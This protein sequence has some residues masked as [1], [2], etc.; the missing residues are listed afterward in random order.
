MRNT[1]KYTKMY[2]GGEPQFVGGDVFR[3][4]IP[5]TEAATATVEP[6][7]I[8]PND[9]EI[10]DAI[11]DAINLSINERKLIQFLKENPRATKTVMS[12]SL[13]IGVAAIDRTIK[14]LKQQLGFLERVGSN[15]T[16]YWKV[17]S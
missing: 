4:T 10:N 13:E 5:L 17:N 2:S 14:K 16:G 15:K 12:T 9:D 7:V 1:Y 3:I 6:E 8:A 11:N